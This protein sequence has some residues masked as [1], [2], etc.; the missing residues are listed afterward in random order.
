MANIWTINFLELWKTALWLT[1]NKLEILMH[2]DHN[3]LTTKY[4]VLFLTH[5]VHRM[6]TSF[7]DSNNNCN[8]L[9]KLFNQ[10]NNNSNNSN[11]N[12]LSDNNNYSLQLPSKLSLK[13]SNNNRCLTPSFKIL[14]VLHNNNNNKIFSLLSSLNHFSRQSHSSSKEHSFK[15]NLWPSRNN[16]NFPK[17]DQMNPWLWVLASQTLLKGSNKSFLSS[18]SEPSTS[19][20]PWTYLNSLLIED[21]LNLLTYPNSSWQNASIHQMNESSL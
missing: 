2:K 19:S 9:S 21:G 6:P 1:M 3:Q 15:I 11:N 12:K 4:K 5:L 16:H 8:L 20:R 10:F 13:F 7:K 17:T 18:I 14:R